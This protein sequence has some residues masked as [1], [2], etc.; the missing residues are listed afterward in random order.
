MEG[1]RRAAEP[2]GGLRTAPLLPCFV[3]QF[4]PFLECRG[5]KEV[6]WLGLRVTPA[7]TPRG[8]VHCPLALCRLAPGR[9]GVNAAA[10]RGQVW[11]PLQQSPLCKAEAGTGQ[12]TGPVRAEP[13]QTGGFWSPVHGLFTSLVGRPP[14]LPDTCGTQCRMR[15]HSKPTCSPVTSWQ[16]DPS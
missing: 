10:S 4:K 7:L 5:R 3:V 6:G 8:T 12:P 13:S 9:R 15:P 2:E 1:T 11:L 14:R 16:P